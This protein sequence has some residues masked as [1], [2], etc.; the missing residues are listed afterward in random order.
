MLIRQAARREQDLR[1]II[2]IPHVSRAADGSCVVKMGNTHVL[3]T[4]SLDKN[5]QGILVEYGVLPGATQPRSGRERDSICF[6][7]QEIQETV[8][9]SLLMVLDREIFSNVGLT[10]DCDVLQAEGSLRAA[11]VSGAYIAVALAL[12]KLTP[13]M[14]P[15]YPLM[16]QIAGLSCG[17]VKGEFILDLDHEEAFQADVIGDFVFNNEGQVVNL[18]FRSQRFAI[19]MAQIGKMTEL[20]LQGSRGIFEAQQAVLGG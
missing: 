6:E 12:K 7:T 1:E 10:V 15:R 18:F 2:F 16:G 11:S 3:C 14:F 13:F 4:A 5:M 9:Q 17:L 19:T 20:A 8:K